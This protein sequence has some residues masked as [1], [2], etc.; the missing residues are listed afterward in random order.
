M[1]NNPFWSK[2]SSWWNYFWRVILEKRNFYCENHE[3]FAMLFRNFRKMSEFLNFLHEISWYFKSFLK[4]FSHF[5]DQKGQFGLEVQSSFKLWKKFETQLH[6]SNIYLCFFSS[7]I[8]KIT[9]FS[10]NSGLNQSFKPQ[11]LKETS[12]FLASKK[13]V[14]VPWAKHSLSRVSDSWLHLSEKFCENIF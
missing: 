10:S 7:Q 12:K 2:N 11:E 1:H 5:E 6:F 3:T 4:E 8:L 13:S 9:I 14:Q